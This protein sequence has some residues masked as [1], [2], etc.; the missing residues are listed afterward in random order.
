MYY[1]VVAITARLEYATIY[2]FYY[3]TQQIRSSTSSEA[4]S[5]VNPKNFNQVK[6]HQAIVE[7]IVVT[8]YHQSSGRG[9]ICMS[10][11]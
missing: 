4:H 10:S 1:Y 3:D 8:N 7:S 6:A 2:C 11:I 9:K 5:E